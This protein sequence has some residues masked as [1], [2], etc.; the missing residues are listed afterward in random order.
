MKHLGNTGQDDIVLTVDIGEG[1]VDI[2]VHQKVKSI[3]TNS[4]HQVR[5]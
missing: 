2:V 4:K 3:A 5:N 1:M